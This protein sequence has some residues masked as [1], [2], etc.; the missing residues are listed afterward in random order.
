MRSAM[1]KWISGLAIACL[2]IPSVA[3]GA[4]DSDVQRAVKA[5]KIGD[6]GFDELMMACTFFQP[7]HLPQ[8]MKN[9][10][11]EMLFCL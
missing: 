7:L 3:L 8:S 10:N 6:Y 4:P 5:S 9:L 2:A 11:L 1:N